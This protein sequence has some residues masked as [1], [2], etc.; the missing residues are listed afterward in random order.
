[1]E[2]PKEH[3]FFVGQDIDRVVALICYLQMSILGYT[4]YVIVG[5]SL[6]KPITGK[7]LIINRME[8]TEHWLT[9]AFF[10]EPWVSRMEREIAQL[11]EKEGQYG[12]Q[13]AV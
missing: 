3:L 9:P 8:G 12:K 2:N 6:T 1:M 5:D 10:T 13:E 4:G 7:G 11:R